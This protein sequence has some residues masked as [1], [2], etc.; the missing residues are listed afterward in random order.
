[1]NNNDF[2]ETNID[3]TKQYHRTTK[4]VINKCNIIFPKDKK[5]QT[6]ILNPKPLQ[7]KSFTKL[8]KSNNPIRPVINFQN[9]PA[10]KLAQL[11]TKCFNNTFKLPYT[12]NEPS[13]GVTL[14][15]FFSS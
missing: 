2:I 9:A 15:Y 6:N 7:I 1:M 4:N 14:T 11:F 12:F 8:H 5:W 3:P 10:Y 13:T